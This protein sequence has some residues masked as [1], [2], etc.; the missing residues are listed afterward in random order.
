MDYQQRYEANY[1]EPVS[2]FGINAFDAILIY[3]DAVRRAE[4]F[5][6]ERV[7]EAIEKTRDVVGANGS[8]NMSDKDHNGL[9]FDSLRLL[10]I[11]K[12]D[13]RIVD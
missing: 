5:E 12:G 9:S 6:K 13:W 3:V 7:R 4:S 1:K 2:A 10:E 8:F 11:E